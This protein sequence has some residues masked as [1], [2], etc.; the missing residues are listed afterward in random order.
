MTSSFFYQVQLDTAR[1]V[2]FKAREEY[3]SKFFPKANDTEGT[4]LDLEKKKRTPS[5]KRKPSKIN[6]THSRGKK[7]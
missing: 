4:D 7:K 1:E 3:R 6:R 5:P 2:I